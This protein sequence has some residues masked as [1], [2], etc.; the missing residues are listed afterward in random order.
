VQAQATFLKSLQQS[1]TGWRKLTDLTIAVMRYRDQTHRAN[2][3]Q[4]WQVTS[5]ETCQFNS[6]AEYDVYIN[7]RISLHTHTNN[8]IIGSTSP[9][10]LF[11]H[12][13]TY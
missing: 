1:K 11:T 10:Y 2:R 5:P 12:A 4:T 6:L 9:A 13:L 3:L 8:Q 7:T